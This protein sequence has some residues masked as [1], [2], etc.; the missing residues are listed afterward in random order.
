MTA[1]Y[2]PVMMG[3]VMGRQE[4]ARGDGAGLQMSADTVTGGDGMAGAGWHLAVTGGGGG[5]LQT[6]G[7]GR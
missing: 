3:A 6:S 1:G 2:R 5:G 7:D 4:Q